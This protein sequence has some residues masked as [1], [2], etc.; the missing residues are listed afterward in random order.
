MVVFPHKLYRIDGVVAKVEE[1]IELPH[2]AVSW[3]EDVFDG[4]D[5]L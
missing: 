5:I 2:F 3:I 1:S 4:E